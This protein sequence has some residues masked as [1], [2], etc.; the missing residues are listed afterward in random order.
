VARGT[1]GFSVTFVCT[2]NRARSPVAQELLRRLVA[3]L[4]V[5]VD[6]Y[7]TLD[8]GPVAALPEAEAA[9]R[10]LGVDL[11]PHRARALRPGVLADADLVVG[12][13]PTHVATAVVDAGA[14]RECCFTILELVE[15]LED[16]PTYGVRSPAAVVAQANARRSGSPLSAPS[17]ADPLGGTPEEF[18]QT[19]EM[20]DRLV[21][22]I[23]RDVFGVA[24]DVPETAPK[25]VSGWRGLV[26]RLRWG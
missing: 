15:L 17:V 11:G 10:P 23:A 12:F 20:V 9:A 8:L 22:V 13:E 1:G 19:V 26:G 25:P 4:D 21:S 14:R 16:V 24:V 18:R 3:G 7:G 2:G 6:S 5:S